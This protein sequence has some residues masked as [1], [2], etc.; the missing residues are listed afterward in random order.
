ML[1]WEKNGKFTNQLIEKTIKMRKETNSLIHIF[2][3]FIQIVFF[4]YE[5]KGIRSNLF[6]I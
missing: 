6:I 2:S 3:I 5:K 1:E 4:S